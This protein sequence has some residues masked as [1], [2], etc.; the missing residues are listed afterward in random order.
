MLL[1]MVKLQK[2]RPPTLM[3][4]RMGPT[5][6]RLGIVKPQKTIW[7]LSPK[8]VP[9][10]PAKIP[11]Q[12]THQKVRRPLVRRANKQRENWMPKSTRPRK[13]KGL[14]IKARHPIKSKP[15]RRIQIAPTTRR[16]LAVRKKL[17]PRNRFLLSPRTRDPNQTLMGPRMDR[18]PK[19]MVAAKAKPKLSL[20]PTHPAR[21]VLGRP[22]KMPKLLERLMSPRQK[23]WPSPQKRLVQ[24]FLLPW[25][26]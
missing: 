7:M 8:R 21:R 14:K 20:K 3:Q 24:R 19:Q 12:Q 16:Q 17:W 9:R 2:P 13:A 25:A 23:V 18:R 10:L 4:P 1:G 11:V 26:Q 15:T 22:P 6:S 5:R